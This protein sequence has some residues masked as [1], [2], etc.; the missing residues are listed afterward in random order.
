MSSVQGLGAAHAAPAAAPASDQELR[1]VARQFESL[2]THMLLKN[3]RA[4]SFGP[5]I[6]DNDQSEFY[7]DMFDER[8]AREMAKG[9][10]MG[11]AELLVRQ[12]GRADAG[13]DG[14]TR[15]PLSLP[16]TR[17]AA[18]P[19]VTPTDNDG[20]GGPLAFV[21]KL[22]PHARRIG[23]VLGV[24][25]QFLL[26]QAALETGWGRRP[27][28]TGDGADSHNL[29][30]IKAGGG[31]Q[32]R[33]AVVGTLEFVQ[34]VAQ[35]Q[36]AVFRAYASAGESFDDYATLLRGAS[37]YRD[38]L[39][40]GDDGRAFATGLQRAGYATDPNYADKLL[41]IASG[42]TLRTALEALKFR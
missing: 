4:A 5:G 11:I 23:K 13:K 28:R 1:A 15:A 33:T 39:H 29:F 16:A 10:G 37:R 8:L 38:V 18:H 22:L 19:P 17:V 25:P 30:G 7:R 31:W 36:Q 6:M 40:S 35:R 42:K 34:G 41:S 9:G 27:I 14:E 24:A 21:R 12:L 3:M 26:A 32:G 20:E 2:F